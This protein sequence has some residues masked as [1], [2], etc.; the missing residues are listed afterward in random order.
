MPGSS[1]GHQVASTSRQG[2]SASSPVKYVV[3]SPSRDRPVPR[4][5]D[6]EVIGVRA[7]GRSIR[8]RT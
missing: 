4:A 7:V 8:R 3:Q 6:Q 2:R 5:L 1:R